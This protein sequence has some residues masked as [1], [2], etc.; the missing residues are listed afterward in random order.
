MTVFLTKKRLLLLGILL[1]MLALTLALVI[2]WN[3]ETQLPFEH[4]EIIYE[5]ASDYDVP[6]ELVFSV[7]Y[8]ESSFRENALSNRG[9]MGLM[10]LMP[11]TFEEQCHKVGLDPDAFSP[12]D[13]A[14][15]IRCG[16]HYLQELYSM[17]GTWE[18]AITA[19]NAGMG[20]VR[21]WLSSD[22][23]ADGEGGLALI[24]FPETDAYLQRVLENIPLYRDMIEKQK[25]KE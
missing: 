11:A 25:D 23:Y 19:Y 5:C 4:E 13:P 2:F 10:Q 7:I 22:T 9:A 6:P 21:N 12:Y 3:L 14:V 18:L 17:F 1:L 15:N 24:P 16:T 20:N 8:A